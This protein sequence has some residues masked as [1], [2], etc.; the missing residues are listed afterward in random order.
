MTGRPFSTYSHRIT[1]SPTWKPQQKLQHASVAAEKGRLWRSRLFIDG[2]W[3]EQDRRDGR[4]RERRAKINREGCKADNGARDRGLVTFWLALC[5]NSEG[6]FRSVEQSF[7][8][9]FLLL[10]LCLLGSD[11]H[12]LNITA[13]SSAHMCGAED[14]SDCATLPTLSLGLG[15][16]LR[17]VFPGVQSKTITLETQESQHMPPTHP[18][19]LPASTILTGQRVLWIWTRLLVIGYLR[20]L[21]KKNN[22]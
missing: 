9:S 16:D 3:S 5:V 2:V 14:Q 17:T 19:S 1:T 22:N 20:S 13:T 11:H 15:S 10:L 6:S 21:K 7:P 12:N 8:N 4:G 18:S